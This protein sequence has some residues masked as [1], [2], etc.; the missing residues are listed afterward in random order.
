MAAA[1]GYRSRSRNNAH[2][3]V[4]GNRIAQL[5][6]HW[7]AGIVNSSACC[8]QCR[9]SLDINLNVD[10]RAPVTTIASAPVVQVGG[11]RSPRAVISWQSR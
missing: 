9:N 1:A 10:R 7:L 4:A 8:R 5:V 6:A 2:Y 3:V 11:L